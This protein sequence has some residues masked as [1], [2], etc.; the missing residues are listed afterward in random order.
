MIRFATQSDLPAVRTL[1]DKCFG[2]EGTQAFNDYFFSQCY[3]PS[4]TLLLC[5]GNELC[6]M[7]QMLPYRLRTA[8]QSVPVTYIYG[9][10]TDPTC[11][12]KGY[13]AKLLEHSF[14]LDEQAGRAASILIPAEEWLFEFYRAFGYETAFFVSRTKIP[15]AERAGELPTRL[16]CEHADALKA[17]YNAHAPVPFVERE[18]SQWC[19]QL[20]LFDAV[21]AG[22]YGWWDSGR[23]TAYAFC[24]AD[25][26]QE[27]VGL[28]EAKAAGLA[29]VLHIDTLPV[30]GMGEQTPFGC[31]RPHQGFCLA[32]A[33]GYMNLLWN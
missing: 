6:A 21:G 27:A 15:C 2:E 17:L 3:T 32:H 30:V 18:Q 12:R 7:T 28:D 16:G 23:L 1:W 25:G 5:E 29:Q 10:C 20:A 14:M 9:A 4:H 13:M 26:V 24:W 31:L 22:A 8:Q 11:R 19:A 33:R